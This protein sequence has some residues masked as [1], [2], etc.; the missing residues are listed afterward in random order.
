VTS[1][2][3]YAAWYRALAGLKIT[4]AAV[5]QLSV[6]VV[7]AFGAALFLNERLSV[8]LAVCS[9]AIL[10]GVGCAL[11]GRIRSV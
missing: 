3:G 8:R 6:P 10:G 1:G 7:A 5:A 4:Q 11:V 9:A 2:L